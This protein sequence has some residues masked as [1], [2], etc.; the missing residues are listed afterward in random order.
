[1]SLLLKELKGGGGGGGWGGVGYYAWW[2]DYGRT[3]LTQTPK[4]NEKK[5]KSA[6]VQVIRVAVEF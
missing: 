1:M 3:P 5:F 4:G 2:M 6:R